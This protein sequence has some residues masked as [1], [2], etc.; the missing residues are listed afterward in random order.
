MS[1][2]NMFIHVCCNQT[3]AWVIVDGVVYDVT[4]WIDEHP[5]SP[6]VLLKRAGQDVTQAFRCP[7]L[8]CV[9]VR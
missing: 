7:R 3:D 4:K 1:F 5:G 9:R 8:L 2:M 6:E